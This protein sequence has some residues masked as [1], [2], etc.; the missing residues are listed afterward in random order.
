MLREFVLIRRLRCFNFFF[1][2]CVCAALSF[3]RSAAQGLPAV[4]PQVQI[5]YFG[6]E[7]GFVVGT[8]PVTLLCVARN[9]GAVP[10]LENALRLRCYTLAGLDYTTGETWPALPALAPGQTIA[11]RWTLTPAAQSGPLIAAALLTGNNARPLSGRGPKAASAES[12]ATEITPQAVLSVIPR[13]PSEPKLD[14]P[15]LALAA[16]PLSQAAEAS[17]W[18]GND[19][20]GAR[21]LAS[22]NREPVLLLGGRNGADWK[23]VAVSAPLFSVCSG[24]EGQIPWRQTFR[25]DDSR[26]YS[27]KETA[28]LTLR[29][30]LGTQW[31]GEIVLQARSGT[32][33]M[34][35]VLRLTARRL[36]RLRELAAPRLLAR[37][38]AKPMS[39]LPNGTVIDFLDKPVVLPASERIAAALVA[40]FVVG[41]TWP[42]SFAY[43]NWTAAPDS[44][45][46]L[47]EFPILGTTWRGG[48]RG[49]LMQ[50]GET[51]EVPF[52]LFAYAPSETLRDALRFLMN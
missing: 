36:M 18:V 28:T 32:A 37:D 26:A 43:A 14:A 46:S 22:A 47:S 21:L 27:E 51:I 49:T 39:G 2:V 52:R 33:V 31:R 35:G 20:I 48:E 11:Y 9:T 50:P 34:Q 5:V 38:A 42:K 8:Q 25:W 29:G 13:F 41:L 4:A 3:A 15:N 6:A 19:R 10:I 1:Y 40:P 12:S 44:A 23:V 17:A 7:R 45:A 30:S 24:E 16:P